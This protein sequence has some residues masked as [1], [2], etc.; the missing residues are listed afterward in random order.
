M[1]WIRVDG[2]AY[3]LSCGDSL[4]VVRPDGVLLH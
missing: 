1:D 4:W 3:S 2:E